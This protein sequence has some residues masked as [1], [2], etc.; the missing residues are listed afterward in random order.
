MFRNLPVIQSFYYGKASKNAWPWRLYLPLTDTFLK[1][2]Q[3]VPSP[4]I[5]VKKCSLADHER[6]K[7]NNPFFSCMPKTRCQFILQRQITGG[8][9][10]QSFFQI[11]N[12]VE[13]RTQL[14]RIP[15]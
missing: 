9:Y 13:P 3:N 10:Q 1:T 12:A 8:Q 7:I 5:K 15:R 4:T 2:R 6:G 11:I 14:T